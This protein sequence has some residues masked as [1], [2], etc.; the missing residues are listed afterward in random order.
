MGDMQSPQHPL[1]VLPA[2]LNL[3]VSHYDSLF[4]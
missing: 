1:E 2:M 4:V 3:V